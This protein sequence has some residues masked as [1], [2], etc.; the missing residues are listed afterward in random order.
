M[1]ASELQVRRPTARKSEAT[2]ASDRVAEGREPE[3]GER[4]E[5]E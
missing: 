5:G 4:N 3:S 1:A 2:P